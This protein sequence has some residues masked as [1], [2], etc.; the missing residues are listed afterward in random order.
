MTVVLQRFTEIGIAH[1]IVKVGSDE[2]FMVFQKTKQI[3]PLF[4]V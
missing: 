3:N 4:K 1:I 2:L